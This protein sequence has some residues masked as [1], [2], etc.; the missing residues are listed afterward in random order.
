M[1]TILIVDANEL[2]RDMLARAPAARAARCSSP[3]MAPQGWPGSRRMHRWNGQA[4]YDVDGNVAFTAVAL[5][6]P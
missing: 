4:V 6:T 5:P 2:N 3:P 1:P